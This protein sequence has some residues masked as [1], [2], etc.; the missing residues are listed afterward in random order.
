MPKW[1]EAQVGFLAPQSMH[2]C[3][4][5]E[6]WYGKDSINGWESERGRTS[7]QSYECNWTKQ[8]FRTQ[9]FLNSLHKDD[10]QFMCCC[11][12]CFCIGWER[13]CSARRWNSR[14]ESG[15]N[16][17]FPMHICTSVTW[18]GGR[19]G[20]GLLVLWDFFVP[21]SQSWLWAAWKWTLVRPLGQS[22]L[23]ASPFQGLRAD[24]NVENNLL[25]K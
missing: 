24:V 4:T 15:F 14:E 13:G 7:H 25:N 23:Q 11:H 2:D 18:E 20:D 19:G 10:A 21:C 17:P 12:C 3:C 6:T 5:R 8:L 16:E 1:V 22:R 9:G